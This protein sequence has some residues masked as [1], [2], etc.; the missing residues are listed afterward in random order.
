MQ[1][2]L[3]RSGIKVSAMGIGLWAIGGPWTINGGAAGWGEVDDDESIRAIHAAMEAG[4]NFF[5]TAANYGA[6]HSEK[7]FAKAIGGRRDEVVIATK[8]GFRVKEGEGIVEDYPDPGEVSSRLR[9]DCE[10]SLRRLN[11]DVIDLYQLHIN[12]YDPDRAGEVR[13]T[14]EGLVKDGLIR[15]YGWSTDFPAG[16]RVFAQG[17]HCTS[18]QA[19]HSVIHDSPAILEVCNEFNLACINRGPLAMGMLTGKY[20]STSTWAANDV[21][22]R[23]WFQEG[24]KDRTLEH[25]PKIREILT[26]KGRTLAQGA[27]A[28]LWGR[29]EH[30]LPIPGVRTVAQVAENAG[31]MA[32]GSLTP[33]QMQEIEVLLGRAEA[34]AA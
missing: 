3:G 16:A 26:S 18:L 31:A 10:A 12:S 2:E 14:L 25:L 1:R 11:T 5:D 23:D 7:V 24:F 27:L 15:Y 34:A 22:T 17:A 33:D 32:F 6:G 29:S 9:T 20:D 28:W 4:I 13:D 30:N 8:F 19:N 21:R